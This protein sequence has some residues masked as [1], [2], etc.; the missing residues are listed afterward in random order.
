MMAAGGFRVSE[1]KASESSAK[2]G[3]KSTVAWLRELPA[4][5]QQAEWRAGFRRRLLEWFSQNGRDLPWR[6]TKDPYA[7]WL[8]EIML[9]QTQTPTVVPYFERFLAAFPTLQALAQADQ[10]EVLRLWEGLG[11]YRRAVQ[12]HQAAQ[13]IVSELGGQ[14]PQTPEELLQL[15]G[16]GRYTAGAILSIAFDKRQPILEANTTRLWSRLLA[17]RAS[18]VSA[19]AQRLFWYMA[20]CILPRRQVGRFNQ[21]LMELGSMVCLPRQPRCEQCPVG[22][23]CLAYRKG[24]QNCL[25]CARPKPT[26]Q[27]CQE[28]ALIVRRNDQVLLRRIPEGQRWAGL[29]D[30][31]RFPLLPEFVEQLSSPVASEAHQSWLFPSVAAETGGTEELGDLETGKKGGKMDI[32]FHAAPKSRKPRKTS[33]L[34]VSAHRT[35]SPAMAGFLIEQIRQATGIEVRAIRPLKTIRYAVTRY[36]VR[37]DCYE[38]EY[39]GLADRAEVVWGDSSQEAEPGGFQ[40]VRLEALGGLP[41]SSPARR[42]AQLAQNHSAGQETDM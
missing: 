36:R 8:S 33:P 41:M 6:R 21:A 19:Q 2:A 10:A 4:E 24:L 20:E 22:R 7:I 40:W 13:K 28:A 37:M 27:F 14:F 39:V 30:F 23:F 18:T 16:I 42:L 31:P 9:Q 15:P 5:W 29:W 32:R 26:V 38:A 1:S 34:A 35:I 12:L 11:Y 17:Y 3:E 25:P